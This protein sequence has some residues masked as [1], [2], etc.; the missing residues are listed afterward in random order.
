M[1][2]ENLGVMLWHIILPPADKVLLNVFG[3]ESNIEEHAQS[4][5]CYDV[6]NINASNGEGEYM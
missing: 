1:T 5:D 6:C 2:L 4:N 3:K